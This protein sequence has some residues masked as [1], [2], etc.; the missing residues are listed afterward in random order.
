MCEQR[1][2]LGGRARLEMSVVIA[3]LAA[4]RGD[5]LAAARECVAACR[6]RVPAAPD[7]E[8]EKRDQPEGR[9]ASDRCSG[10]FLNRPANLLADAENPRVSSVFCG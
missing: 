8:R 3:R 5:Q 1:D 2:E 7:R 9:E 10:H 4:E 6:G